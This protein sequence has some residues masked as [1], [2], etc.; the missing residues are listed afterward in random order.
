M[1]RRIETPM[2]A[3][4]LAVTSL[5]V[6]LRAQ[7]AKQSEREELYHRYLEFPSCVKGG[8]LEPLC[9]PKTS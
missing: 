1:T 2:I 6:G 3:V 8:S 4:L 9:L 5:S 7:G